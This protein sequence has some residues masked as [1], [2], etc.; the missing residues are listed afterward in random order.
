MRDPAV[1]QQAI[2]PAVAVHIRGVHGDLQ[3]AIK[4]TAL[5][6]RAGNLLFA[7]FIQPHAQGHQCRQQEDQTK[8]PVNAQ[9]FPAANTDPHKNIQ[10]QQ[11]QCHPQTGVQL[12]PHCAERYAFAGVSQPGQPPKRCQSD[13]AGG[14]AGSFQF[15]HLRRI[16]LR[17]PLFHD[18][19]RDN[20][21]ANER[22]EN[23]RER[24]GLGKKCVLEQRQAHE[25]PA[26]RQDS[27]QMPASERPAFPQK[28]LR[29]QE[30]RSRNPQHDVVFPIITEQPRRDHRHEQPTQRAP[31]RNAEK[32]LRQPFRF[33]PQ[34]EQ[35]PM[36]NHAAKK[37]RE[38]EQHH[39][40]NNVHAHA[41]KHHPHHPT[42]T[43]DE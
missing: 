29:S 9:A 2:I 26:H 22:A 41:L 37:Q 5:E 19:H 32:V 18:D 1:L 38:A 7:V 25:H 21:A 12:A 20:P 16:A 40:Q 3:R 11:R 6:L 34:P 13:A 4:V 14:H 42:P 17:P 27:A 28:R 15:H 39:L 35:F 10:E 43:G 33:R 36:A 31:G 24:N 23:Q 30:Q 8:R